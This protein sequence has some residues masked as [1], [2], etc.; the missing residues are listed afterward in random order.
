[1]LAGLRRLPDEFLLVPGRDGDVHDL[2]CGVVEQRLHGGKHPGHLEIPGGPVRLVD[3]L[4]RQADHIEPRLA[5]GR[6]VRGVY[7]TARP[8]DAD[9]IV[10]FRAQ[11]R[12]VFQVQVHLAY[13]LASGSSETQTLYRRAGR[14]DRK[15]A[16]NHLALKSL[17]VYHAQPR[18]QDHITDPDQISMPQHRK[19]FSPPQ[20][21][22]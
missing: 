17:P 3:V 14:P 12:A 4:V 20:V 8:D 7:D 11:Y 10:R 13:L 15:N 22:S 21:L 6:K 16:S 2:D 5:V 9:S 18:I 1:M 19:A